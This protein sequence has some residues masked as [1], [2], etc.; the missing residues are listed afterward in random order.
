MKSVKNQTGNWK[1][2][3]SAGVGEFTITLLP[4]RQAA[5]YLRGKNEN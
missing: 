1:E 4:K 5:F 3:P 2:K